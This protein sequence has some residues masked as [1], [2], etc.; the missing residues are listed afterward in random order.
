VAGEPGLGSY[1]AGLAAQPLG[2]SARLLL[3]ARA[4]ELAALFLVERALDQ[5]A[6]RGATARPER[7]CPRAD[8]AAPRAAGDCCGEQKRRGADDGV[9]ES[10]EARVTM[11]TKERKRF[12][13][14]LRGGSP[15]IFEKARRSWV[16]RLS[17]F[18]VI[19]E[20]S[21]ASKPSKMP[22][23][24]FRERKR[25]GSSLR[26]LCVLPA[27]KVSKQLGSLNKHP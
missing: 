19:E 11:E 26:G 6:P 18:C 7:L 27:W 17:G 8:A 14:S 9:R 5:A 2:L 21:P 24:G 10:P 23:S 16:F 25:F 20:L 22:V 3:P 1:G 15:V 13:S 12:G 4:R